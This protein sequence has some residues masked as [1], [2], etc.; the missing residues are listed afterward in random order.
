VRE[1][2]QMS[3]MPVFNLLAL[4]PGHCF[5]LLLSSPAVV[6]LWFECVPQGSSVESSIPSVVGLRGGGT[7]ERW[8]LLRGP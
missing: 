1:V 5:L 2:V 3:V 4:C 8:G 6:W 7:F